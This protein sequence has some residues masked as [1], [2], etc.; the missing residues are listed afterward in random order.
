MEGLSRALNIFLGKCGTPQYTKV[1][2][3]NPVTMTVSPS[4]KAVRPFVVT[5]ILRN[6][7]LT[8][9]G[10]DSLIELQEKLHH[11]ICRKR[12][13]VAIGVHDLDTLKPPFLYSADPPA[14]IKFRP[15]NQTREF[16]ADELM[17]FYEADNHLKHY[18]HIIREEPLYP[19]IRDS[20]GVVLSMPPI[21]NG[22]HS[23]VTL[24]TRNMYFEATATDETKV[25]F[26]Y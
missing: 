21:I 20:N 13:F 7:N 16:R 5:A 25:S 8:Q 11:N 15:L 22:D 23:K 26:R 1:T 2:P 17:T 24:N 10:Y 4:T 12:T 3:P 19:V 18:L 14:E 6:V 9:N